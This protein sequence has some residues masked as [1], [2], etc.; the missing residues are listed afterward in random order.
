MILAPSGVSS[1]ASNVSLKASCGNAAN[2]LEFETDTK[3]RKVVYCPPEQTQRATQK[4]EES[5]TLI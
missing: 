3:K 1:K 2:K 4:P 5:Q